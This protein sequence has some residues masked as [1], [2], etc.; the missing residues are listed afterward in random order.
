VT[1]FLSESPV[2]TLLICSIYSFTFSAACVSVGF[3]CVVR[4]LCLKNITFVEEAIGETLLRILFVFL[5]L[6]TA[7]CV[8]TVQAIHPLNYLKIFKALKPF[9]NY[10]I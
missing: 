8:T 9:T 4:I 1:G 7:I 6:G 2:V 3:I 5:I 10:V